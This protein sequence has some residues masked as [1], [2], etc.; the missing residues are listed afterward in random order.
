MTQHVR[1]RYRNHRKATW[2]AVFVVLVAA[3]L[4]LVLPALG[5]NNTNC[6]PANTSTCVK[7][8]STH[9]GVTPS[10][11]PVGGSNFS[12]AKAGASYGGPATP[13]GMRE[14]QI[15]KPTPGSYTDPATGVIF[16]VLPPTGNQAPTSFF[17]FRV[18]GG[19]AVVYH[20]G[21]K[22]GTNVAWYDYFNNMPADPALGP[23]RGVFSDDDL[24]STPDSKYT[25]SKPS[26]FVAS[27]TTFC[28]S[29]PLTV[30]PSCTN[31][32]FG[33]DLGGTGGTVQYSAQ[34]TPE[35]GVCKQDLV[36][37]ASFTSGTNDQSQMFA[38]LSPL[39]TGGAQNKVVEH[40]VWTGIT[41]D[42]QNPITLRYDDTAPF[43]GVDNP[44]TSTNEGWR[45]M[46]LCGSD[47]RPFPS[48][49]P[50]A[51]NQSPFDLGGNTPAMPAADGDGPHTTCMLQSTDSAG[52][53]T[54][55]RSYD[56]WLFSLIDGARNGT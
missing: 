52:T 55:G 11:A 45:T 25:A 51:A 4:V 23:Q 1:K 33:T 38:T 36:F 19:A 37:M 2:A 8:A 32:F 28:Y 30:Q 5:I 47:P 50:L 41:K 9:Q 22:G 46:M 27:I 10:I 48:N 29:A 14:F 43:N 40:I 7:P 12:C 35:N 6:N 42:I 21:V 31:P 26:F 49:P 3:A 18:R 56:A 13:S 54:S 53:G 20:V 17:S 24:H 34:L 39:T 15:S 44:G 16:D